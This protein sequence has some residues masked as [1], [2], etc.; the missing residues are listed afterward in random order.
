MNDERLSRIEAKL[1]TMQGGLADVQGGLAEVR[2]GLTEVQGGLTDLRRHMDVLHEDVLDRLN[3]VT[4]DPPAIDEKI[5]RGDNA[6]RAELNERIG[7][8][9]S[10]IRKNP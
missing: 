1:D 2:G 8:I 6:V 3:A 9:E 10:A 5:E 4:L 7:V